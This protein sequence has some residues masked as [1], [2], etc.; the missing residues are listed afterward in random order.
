[1]QLIVGKTQLK[2]LKTDCSTIKSLYD[3]EESEDLEKLLVVEDTRVVHLLPQATMFFKLFVERARAI[4]RREE[5]LLEFEERRERGGGGVVGL[6][7][8]INLRSRL[9]VGVNEMVK[10]GIDGG[11]EDE[12]DVGIGLDPGVVVSISLRRLGEAGIDEIN[13]AVDPEELCDEEIPS[14]PVGSTDELGESVN[15]DERGLA[16]VLGE[17][18]AR[19]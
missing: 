16:G 10:R 18:R 5:V 9:V 4:D 19:S 1:M 8:R 17:R 3:R 15:L 2:F 7:L 12:S 6:E 14:L 11:E 13:R